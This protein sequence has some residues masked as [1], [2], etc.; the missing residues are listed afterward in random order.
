MLRQLLRTAVLLGLAIAAV[1]HTPGVLAGS[2]RKTDP[3][4]LHRSIPD[5]QP[6]PADLTSDTCRYVPVFGAGDPGSSRIVRGVSRFGQATIDPSGSTREVSYA[7]EEHIYVVLD[8]SAEIRYAG[9]GAALRHHD[10]VYVPAGL[11]HDIRNT[12]SQP[13]RLLVMGF[14][15][16]HSPVGR[17]ATKPLSANFDDVPTQTVSGHPPSV[18]YRLLV[19]DLDSKRDK[20]AAGETVTSLFIMEFAPGGTNLPHHHEREEEI[21]LVLEGKGEMVAGSGLDGI[22]GRYPAKAGDAYF[23]RLNATVGFYNDAGSTARILAVRS[24][25]PFGK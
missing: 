19:G 1:L 23:V 4:F 11:K 7:A 18:Q 16:G 10:F 6:E 15:V 8:G 13:A 2:E 17:R 25:F 21:Y 9:A 14:K 12:G 22:E 20:I 5:L 3:T 24:L